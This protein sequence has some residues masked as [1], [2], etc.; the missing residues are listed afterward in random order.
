MRK[1]KDVTPTGRRPESESESESHTE[2][3]SESESHTDS[4][5]DFQPESGEAFYNY[6]S[7]DIAN[8][9]R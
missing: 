1:M 9:E 3:R 8:I 7:I 4:Q 5:A 6:I 2:S